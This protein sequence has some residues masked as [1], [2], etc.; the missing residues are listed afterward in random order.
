VAAS[1]SAVGTFRTSHHVR[2]YAV[3]LGEPLKRDDAV[4]RIQ[5]LQVI[6][7][8]L[9]PVRV[10]CDPLSTSDLERVAPLSSGATPTKEA[11]MDF[12]ERLFGISP[13]DGDGSLE[14]LYLS[15]TVLCL[16][17]SYSGRAC[18]G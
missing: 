14:A 13:D 5:R 9:Q 1:K 15:A 8:G 7:F 10:S 18:A 12:I 6:A 17:P 11:V 3:R 4:H 2:S 16:P